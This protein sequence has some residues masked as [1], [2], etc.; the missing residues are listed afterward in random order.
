M[1]A[2]NNKLLITNSRTVTLCK[3]WNI[4]KHKLIIFELKTKK[5]RKTNGY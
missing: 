2:L 1:A 5:Q 4:A 3:K